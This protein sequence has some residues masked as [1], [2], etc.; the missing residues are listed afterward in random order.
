MINKLGTCVAAG[1]ADRVLAQLLFPGSIDK[2]ELVHALAEHDSRFRVYNGF[3]RL[4]TEGVQFFNRNLRP[5]PAT[6][7]T[8]E[9]LFTMSRAQLAVA[10]YIRNLERLTF[11]AKNCRRIEKV[12]SNRFLYEM[13]VS[14]FADQFHPAD[15]TPILYYASNNRNRPHQGLIAGFDEQS[16]RLYVTLD[17]ELDYDE[18]EGRLEVN[19]QLVW[20]HLQTTLQQWAELPKNLTGLLP[21]L[22]LSATA[23]VSDSEPFIAALTSLKHPWQR[24]IWGPPGSGKTYLLAQYIA[25][26]LVESSGHVRILL[27]A[28]SN[29]AVDALMVELLRIPQ[30][31]PLLDSRKILRYG[32]PKDERILREERLFGS[33][34]LAGLKRGIRELLDRRKAQSKRDP[35]VKAA[36][37]AELH[38]LLEQLREELKQNVATSQVVATTITSSLMPNSPIFC[39]NPWDIAIVDEVS[40]VST[41]TTIPVLQLGTKEVLLCGD[42][43]QLAPVCEFS[44]NRQDPDISHWIAKNP[45]DSLG[46]SLGD[47]EAKAIREDGR[48]IKISAQRRCASQIWKL[49]SSLYPHVEARVDESM[50]APIQALAPRSGEAV[51][52]LDTS[53][54]QALPEA[55]KEKDITELETVANRYDSICVPKGGSWINLSTATLVVEVL[56]EVFGQEPSTRVGVITPYRA[57]AKYIRTLVD[58]EWPE[59]D[60]NRPTSLLVGTIHAFQG[61]EADLI[62]FDICDGPP[63]NRP[64]R[65]LRDDDG[66]RLF[67]VA[68]TRAK[69]KLIIVGH[70]PWIQEKAVQDPK[71]FA[72]NF[73]FKNNK[74]VPPICRV[75]SE[76]R[77]HHGPFDFRDPEL[78]L[79]PIHRSL[80][81]EL[82]VHGDASI[83]FVN[84]HR[85]IDHNTKA[86]VSRADIAHPSEKVAIFCDGAKYH[87]QADQW[88]KDMK[89][90]RRL[91]LLGWRVIEF[92]GRE[93]LQNPSKCVAQIL[94]GLLRSS[95][96]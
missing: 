90:R 51:C 62:V 54:G 14:D 61:S 7:P 44:S 25:H 49:V 57:Q 71:S 77:G 33:D 46:L 81:T 87:A 69:A 94:E 59:N 38:M 68:I 24:L 56:K 35:E 82:L 91:T 10:K 43:R 1:L 15:E 22:P 86:I 60:P 9:N 37:S 66:F 18:R 12:G 74:D 23:S 11:Q 45:F 58:A 84:E 85:I 70:L 13:S 41:V 76:D 53:S 88:R 89:Q 27:L 47:G 28:P 3:I 80:W 40:M 67:N 52:F 16:E 73:F 92:G 34:Q 63:R 8:Q 50:F 93:I 32:Y 42:P 79:S 20:S 2:A 83:G 6:L 4:S 75:V 5:G 78:I 39:P 64:G 17:S 48:I 65:L 19:K 26:R 31:G 30:L 55:E 96:K 36:F 72:W 95:C 21:A 29:F